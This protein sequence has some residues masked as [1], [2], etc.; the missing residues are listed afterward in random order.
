MIIIAFCEKTS[1]FLPRVLCRRFKHCAPIVATSDHGRQ[2]VM[3]QFIRP[4]HIIQIGMNVRDMN[5]LRRRGWVFIQTN[6]I[7][8][9]NWHGAITCVDLCRHVMGWRRRLLQTPDG[10]YKQLMRENK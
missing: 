6:E 10:L 3:H 2:F 9:N 5:L 4:G 7:P 1:K 8:N